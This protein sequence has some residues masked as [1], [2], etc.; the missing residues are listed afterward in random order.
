M[1]TCRQPAR[2]NTTITRQGDN[3][4]PDWQEEGLTKTEGEV[5]LEIFMRRRT[6][7]SECGEDDRGGGVKPVSQGLNWW[8]TVSL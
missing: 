1:G 2:G 3:H 5:R 8:E 7:S 4:Y 6:T